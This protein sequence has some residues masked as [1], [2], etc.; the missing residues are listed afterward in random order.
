[1]LFRS[2]LQ[3]LSSFLIV[4]LHTRDGIYGKIVSQ[5]FLPVL[6]W[7]PSGFPDVK[8]L[9]H[10]LLVFFRGNFSICSCRLGVFVG[11]GGFRIFPCCHLELEPIFYVL[12]FGFQSFG[13]LLVY[14][15]MINVV[16]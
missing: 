7:F 12:N 6:M 15:N 13:L 9:L 8:G 14:G 1:M 11:G 4:C 3:V 16:Y 5:P 2:K 10:H